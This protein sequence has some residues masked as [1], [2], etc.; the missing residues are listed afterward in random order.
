MRRAIDAIG[1]GLVIALVIAAPA[2]WFGYRNG[3]PLDAGPLDVTAVH[4]YDPQG[5]PVEAFTREPEPFSSS[6]VPVESAIPN[7]LPRPVWQGFGCDEALRMDVRLAD[8]SIVTYGP[9]RYPIAINLLYA[10]VLDIQ[11]GGACRP[12]CGP[13]GAPGP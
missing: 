2:F 4:L 11:T 3:Q 12:N 7:P 13:G 10:T 6:I 9:C 5:P 1:V 8:G